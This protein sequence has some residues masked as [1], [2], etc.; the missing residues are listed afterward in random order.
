ML[1]GVTL[2]ANVAAASGAPSWLLSTAC[3]LTALAAVGGA[4]LRG[5]ATRWL[6]AWRT[7][8]VLAFLWYL[9]DVYPRLGGDGFDYYVI[10]RSVLFDRDLEF[11]NDYKG[12][13]AR[14][15]LSHE[16]KVTSGLPVG[17]GIVWTPAILAAHLGTTVASWLGSQ[18]PPDGFSDPYQAAV[19]TATY[20]YAAIALVLIE[21]LLRRRHGPGVALL[22]VL[23]L[24]LAT[25][26]HFYMVVN[27]SMSHGASTFAAT[28]LVVLW[29]KARRGLEWRP[30][31]LAGL[32]AG[33]MS[34]IRIQDAVLVALPLL[35]L[36]VR[37]RSG[38]LRLGAAFAAG[39]VLAAVVQLLF[40]ARLW[41]P[42]FLGQVA[43]ANRSPG[44]SPGIH[45]VDVLLSPRHGLFV[46]T[47]L[48]LAAALGWLLWLRRERLLAI[49]CGLGFALAVSVNGAMGDWWG[50][51]GFGQR[52]LLG[53]TP[54]F[55]L[56][57]G[58]VVK[59]LGRRPMILV[60]GA[61][62]ALILWNQQFAYIYNARMVS[63]RS[64]E[65][66]LDRLAAAQVEVL[67]Q[68][69]M[70]WADRAPPRLWALAY[71]N[72]KGIWLDE[73]PRSL[74]GRI[75]LGEGE[76]PKDLPIV[77]GRGWY[78]P[79]SDGATRFRQSRGPHSWLRVPIRTCGDLRVVLWAR[80]DVTEVPVKVSLDVNGVPAG[81]A[82]AAPSWAELAYSVP[83]E[84]LRPGF[85][86]L[87]LSYS[88]T[89]KGIRSDFHG[90]NAALSVDWIRF[91]RLPLAELPPELAPSES[92]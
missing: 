78:P 12:L 30:W 35:D 21:A 3:G 73:G 54:L 74:G 13:G 92:P 33:L 43:A 41:G 24:W 16:G 53:L 84:A 46:W 60:A 32:A 31:A 89:P 10:P 72:I 37:R 2:A 83:K 88:A 85:N 51:D 36:A 49:L 52:R 59:L 79:Q 17:L 56:G 29:L 44:T 81:E 50:S 64:Q 71:D 7:A 34:L 90:R 68:D 80:A 25:P 23:A 82:Q 26:L 76:E 62:G 77:V 6:D 70:E 65:V 8:L 69:L 5:P 14:P 75:D 57:L 9:P 28:L 20:L 15:Y 1:A 63:G 55:A 47:P 19:A 22:S 40:W 18:V 48:Y 58:E 61:L 91:E 67:Y 42:D 45:V 66:S 11:A 39:P 4:L 38:G 87:V 27:P 86:T